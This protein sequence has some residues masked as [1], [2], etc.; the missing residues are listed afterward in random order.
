MIKASS[1]RHREHEVD[2]QFLD[3]WSGR[4]FTGESLSEAEMLLLFEAARWAP[5]SSNFQP[6]RFLYARRDSEFWPAFLDLLA[7]GNRVWAERAGAL[8]LVISRLQSDEQRPCITHSYDSGAAWMSLALQASLSGIV[9]HGIQGFDYERAR[10]VL[11]VPA[12]FAVEAMIVL[13]KPATPDVLPEDLRR[14]ETPSNRRPLAQTICHGP[15]S[16]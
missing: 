10:R 1:Q 9:A 16:F 2:P 7:P 15:F 5:S 3:R 11:R 8:V 13:G 12:Q 4:A 6:W 14:R